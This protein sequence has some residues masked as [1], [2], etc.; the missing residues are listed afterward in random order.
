MLTAPHHCDRHLA[1]HARAVCPACESPLGARRWTVLLA[2]PETPRG[3]YDEEVDVATPRAAGPTAARRVAEA[4]IGT[5]LL[6]D[7][8]VQRVVSTW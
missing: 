2:L 1:H 8:R 4:L 5:E 7:L 6:A 3:E